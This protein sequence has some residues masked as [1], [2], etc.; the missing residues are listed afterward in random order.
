MLLCIQ[1]WVRRLLRVGA[2]AL[3]LVGTVRC[4]SDEPPTPTP[5]PVSLRWV[6]ADLKRLDEQTIASEYQKL[7]PEIA[8]KREDYRQ[9]PQAYLTESAP[10]DVLAIIPG[11][12][13]DDA[14]RNDMVADLSDIWVQTGLLDA[15]PKSLQGIS[16]TS[17]KQFYLPVAYEWSAIYYNKAVFAQYG[18]QPPT[19]WDEF[20][21]VC[22]TLLSNGETPL[23][24]AGARSF[25]ALLWFE[26]LNLRLN[27]AAF[28]R[29][30]LAGRVSYVDARVQNVL[31]RW[32]QLF[33]QGYFPERV[34][35]ID[36]LTT[37]TMLVR[38]DK[39][40]LRDGKAVMTLTTSSQVAELPLPFQTELDYFRFPIIDPSVPVAESVA[41]Y[42]YM[43]PRAAA[44]APAR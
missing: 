43:I 33:D 16:A 38:N 12:Y 26:Y 40:M 31:E 17:G 21:R 14:I 18:L 29:D 2:L 4:G 7:H 32:R 24:I 15:L 44:H 9:P 27:G 13:L 41:A 30:L 19:T 5:E 36:E 8:F 22:D 20:I 23:S 10:P 6:T 37:L 28:H 39:G 34:A 42:G 25:N 3:I 35:T 1:M 11:Y